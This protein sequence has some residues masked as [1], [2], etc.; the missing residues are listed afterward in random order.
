MK[1][2]NVGNSF[3]FLST[4]SPIVICLLVRIFFS[5]NAKSSWYQIDSF[6]YI[7]QASAIKEGSWLNI[8]SNGYPLIIAFVESVFN[9][10]ELDILLI[11]TNIILSTLTI[12]LIYFISYRIT[13]NR[14]FSMLTSLAVGRWP[15][16]LNYVNQFMSEVPATFFLVFGM[17]ILVLDRYMLLSGL[18]FGFAATIR[19]SLTPVSLLIATLFIWERRFKKALIL[20][21]ATIIPIITMS[22]YSYFHTGEFAIGAVSTP[23]ILDALNSY[24]GTEDTRAWDAF[25]KDPNN[26]PTLTE[27]LK[28]YFNNLFEGPYYFF[29]QRVA[30]FWELWG[31]WPSYKKH[32][33][34]EKPRSVL[35]QMMIGLRFPLLLFALVCIFKKSRKDMVDLFLFTPALSLTI[36]HILLYAKARYTFPA[37]PFLMILAMQGL[38]MLLIKY[39]P[40]WNKTFQYKQINTDNPWEIMANERTS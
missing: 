4:V 18:L 3:I 24:G 35:V 13:K 2:Y 15:N 32:K 39:F 27:A 23:N 8:F 37:E 14:A 36:I 16:Q 1:K 29:K 33:T 40:M 9:F 28:I 11:W 25:V 30:A 7:K 6:W 5:F 17:A 34:E 21:V 19:T 22:S 38:L 26:N 10:V 31:F 20:L 12:G